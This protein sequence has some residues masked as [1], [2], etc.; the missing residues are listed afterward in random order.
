MKNMVE[1]MEL[2]TKDFGVKES[3]ERM[4]GSM[5]CDFCDG[6]LSN[7]FFQATNFESLK[8]GLDLHQIDMECNFIMFEK[9]KDFQ[10]IV[11]ACHPS[12]RITDEHNNLFSEGKECNYW[13]R[14]IPEHGDYN[15]Y[16]KMYVKPDAE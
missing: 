8:E 9:F 1:N 5:R 4:V 13:I 10:S 16:I 11:D 7:K 12:T 6:I 15:M 2:T 3:Q 14:L